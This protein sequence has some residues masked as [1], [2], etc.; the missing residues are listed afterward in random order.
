[1]VKRERTIEE[2]E[3]DAMEDI[4]VEN[5][6]ARIKIRKIEIDVIQ[7]RQVDAIREQA[8]HAA[9]ELRC[10]CVGMVKGHRCTEGQ[11]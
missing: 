3:A 2:R 4:A 6:E 7:D 9:A 1:M 10:R 11:I 5:E 8:K